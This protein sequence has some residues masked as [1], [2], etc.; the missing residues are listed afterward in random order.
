MCQILYKI[1]ELQLV[2]SHHKTLQQVMAHL[3]FFVSA[4]TFGEIIKTNKERKQGVNIIK[5]CS[6]IARSFS[7][8]AKLP[9]CALLPWPESPFQ[10]ISSQ[11]LKRLYRL[12]VEEA[13]F[14]ESRILEADVQLQCC[15]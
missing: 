13:Q 4:Q 11:E 1:L 12:R 2:V 3:V 6:K 7:F 14:V 5:K 9:V 8:K 10:S 15:Q